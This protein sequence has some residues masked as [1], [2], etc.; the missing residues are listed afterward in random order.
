MNY[1]NYSFSQKLNT[2]SHQNSTKRLEIERIQYENIEKTNNN[3]IINYN[4]VKNSSL[5]SVHKTECNFNLIKYSD[6]VYTANRDIYRLKKQHKYETN[7]KIESL[8]ASN[9]GVVAVSHSGMIYKIEGD[10]FNTCSVQNYVHKSDY[11]R[12]LDMLIYIDGNDSVFLHDLE[13]NKQVF[14]NFL[15]SRFTKIHEDGNILLTSF[16]KTALNDV[17]SMNRLVEFDVRC[18]SGLFWNGHYCVLVVNNYLMCYDMRKF[19]NVGNIMAHMEDINCL[20]GNQYFVVTTSDNNTS[21]SVPDIGL[22]VEKNFS[23][24]CAVDCSKDEF[25]VLKKNEIYFYKMQS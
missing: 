18:N 11:H 9:S 19:E 22:L 1:R 12:E 23:G 7:N 20:C 16:E 14:S 4:N 25:G 17:R 3:R 13:V 2:F 10:I 15:R 21:V 6:D 5:Q 8:Y 24:G